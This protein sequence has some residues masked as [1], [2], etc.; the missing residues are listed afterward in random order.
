MLKLEAGIRCIGLRGIATP[1]SRS[2]EVA[3]SN[4]LVSTPQIERCHLA[5]N[6]KT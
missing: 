5:C 4:P 2:V 6:R 3:G 1:P